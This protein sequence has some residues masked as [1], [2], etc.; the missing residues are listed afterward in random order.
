[1]TWRNLLLRAYP[2]SWRDEY[3]EELAGLLARRRLTFTVAADVLGGAARQHLRRDDPWKICGAG[4]FLWFMMT[5]LLAMFFPSRVMLWF[6]SC[7][8]L[9]VLAAGAWTVTRSKA[10]VF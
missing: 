4:L 2:R 6:G 9:I 8:F 10:G 1:M 7:G 3:G 5:G